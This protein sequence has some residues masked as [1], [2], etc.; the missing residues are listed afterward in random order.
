MEHFLFSVGLS[1]N[2]KRSAAGCPNPMAASPHKRP[3]NMSET[4]GLPFPPPLP[5]RG[6]LRLNPA[7]LRRPS[8]KPRVR[9]AA[10]TEVSAPTT[11]GSVP[12]PPPTLKRQSAVEDRP[13]SFQSNGSGPSLFGSV[14]SEQSVP[15]T[16]PL[17]TPEQELSLLD[18]IASVENL[19]QDGANR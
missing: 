4:G 1:L 3:N 12:P 17:A 15:K 6:N 5:P 16:A 19:P 10:D 7:V 11:A 14:D 18:T 8:T 9:Q 2:N 13:N